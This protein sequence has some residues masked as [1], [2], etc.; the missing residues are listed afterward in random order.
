MIGALKTKAGSADAYREERVKPAVFIMLAVVALVAIPLAWW[1]LK[2]GAEGSKIADTTQYQ[3]LVELV[4]RDVKTVQRMLDNEHVDASELRRIK[5]APA[6]TL[7]TPDVMPTNMSEAVG[8]ATK[9][10]KP[11]LSG[12]YWSAHDPMAT[13][14]GETY[15]TGEMV[16]G[17]RIV[18]IRETEVVFEDPMGEKIVIYFY[19]YPAAIKKQKR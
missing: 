12:I 9:K 3:S 13:I 1:N 6:S 2:I 8:Q 15:R 18:E 10:F 16:Q 5:A 14:N 19:D 4:G 17:H 7:I 11:E